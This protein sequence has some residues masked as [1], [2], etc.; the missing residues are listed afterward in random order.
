MYTGIV[1]IPCPF[2]TPHLII[3]A[4]TKHIDRKFLPNSITSNAFSYMV[5]WVEIDQNK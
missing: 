2:H 4:L 1:F 3:A 5:A